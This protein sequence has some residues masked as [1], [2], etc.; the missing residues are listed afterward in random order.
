M[1]DKIPKIV[2]VIEAFR[3]QLT[4][5]IDDMEMFE[6]N[7]EF[8]LLRLLEA[9]QMDNMFLVDEVDWFLFEARI[10]VPCKRGQ[11]LK[12]GNMEACLWNLLKVSDKFWDVLNGMV[13][14]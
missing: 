11:L 10:L 8:A 13:E 4:A 3:K 7:C 12:N 2:D 9:L 6:V 14:E 1:N 5:D